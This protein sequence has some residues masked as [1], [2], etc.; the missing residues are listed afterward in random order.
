MSSALCHQSWHRAAPCCHHLQSQKGAA[1]NVSSFRI[2]ALVHRLGNTRSTPCSGDL[3]PLRSQQ[4]KAPRVMLAQSETPDLQQTGNQSV[5]LQTA[6][7]SSAFSERC[8]AADRH[9]SGAGSN[10]S[11][12][13]NKGASGVPPLTRRTAGLLGL[14]IPLV[15]IG[16]RKALAEGW[17]QRFVLLL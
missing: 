6:N 2:P 5:G 1:L 13:P 15:L 3:A 14:A 10:E 8:S 11:Q 17:P 16:G 9:Q 7:V 4:C 12:H